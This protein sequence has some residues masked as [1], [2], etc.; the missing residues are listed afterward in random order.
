MVEACRTWHVQQDSGG[1]SARQSQHESVSVPIR[2]DPCV[3]ALES[4]TRPIPGA[5]NGGHV[6]AWAAGLGGV[7][8]GAG[9]RSPAWCTWSRYTG[10]G[11]GPRALESAPQAG[12]HLSP[13]PGLSSLSART[14]EGRKGPGWG[15]P[16]SADGT[17]WGFAEFLT[18]RD[19]WAEPARG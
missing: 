10:A 7:R 15:S 5:L 11:G 8:G 4:G 12:P 16:A 14:G 19:R 9:H 2:W 1:V 6:G 3:G 17:P 18:W 13:P